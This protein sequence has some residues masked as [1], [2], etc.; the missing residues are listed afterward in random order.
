M[1]SKTWIGV[2]NKIGLDVKFNSFFSFFTLQTL[3]KKV[4]SSHRFERVCECECVFGAC[5]KVCVC[6]IAQRMRETE[7]GE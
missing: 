1:F 6:V 4:M 7:R 5:L 3:M 2:S